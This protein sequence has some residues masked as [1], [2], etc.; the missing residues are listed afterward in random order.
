MA[1]EYKE[2]LE[3]RALARIWKAIEPAKREPLME[4]FRLLT[5]WIKNDMVSAPPPEPAPASGPEGGFLDGLSP[6]AKMLVLK[7][8]TAGRGNLYDECM[9][10]A[11]L[12]EEAAWQRIREAHGG[13]A[14]LIPATEPQIRELIAACARRA[15]PGK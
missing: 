10:L 9:A 8:L 2:T 3:W 4:D 7:R 5:D 6:Q 14:E 15:R 11:G 13:D 1:E 12:G